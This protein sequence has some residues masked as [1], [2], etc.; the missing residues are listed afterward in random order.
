MEED[1]L[2]NRFKGLSVKEFVKKVKELKSH[3]EQFDS[4]MIKFKQEIEALRE[5][6]KQLRF[7]NMRKR[8][9]DLKGEKQ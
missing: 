8:L 9:A 1:N 7:I 3:E 2:D 4:N 6:D 5:Y